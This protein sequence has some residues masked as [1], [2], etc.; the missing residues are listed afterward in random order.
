QR[1]KEGRTQLDPS[2][3]LLAH[4]RLDLYCD[5]DSKHPMESAEGKIGMGCTSC[6][7][8]SGQETNFV[9]AAH[10]PRDIFVDSRTGEPVL[11]T[12]LTHDPEADHHEFKLDS[13]LA[14]VYPEHAL[15]PQLAST[16]LESP[17]AEPASA[18]GASE[19]KEKA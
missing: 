1:K 5:P 6:H 3:A 15:T 17:S 12:Q 10:S 7:D 19:A 18:G 2:A 13:M 16:H 4:P 8:G 14:A 11:K 9:L